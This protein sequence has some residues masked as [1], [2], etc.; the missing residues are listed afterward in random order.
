V[1]LIITA[2]HGNAEEM[3]ERDGS[4]KTSHTCNAIPLNIANFHPDFSLSLVD[5]FGER[6]ASGQEGPGLQDVAPTILAIMGL[7]K[8]AEMDGI[9]LVKIEKRS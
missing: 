2:D 6:P 5:S 3:L 1:V 4:V 9:S 8:P 7:P